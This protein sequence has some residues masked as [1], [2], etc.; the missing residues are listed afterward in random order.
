[1]K[2]AILHLRRSDPVLRDVIDRVG[3]YRQPMAPA[4][5]PAL[6][7]S[8]VYQQLHGKAAATIFGRLEAALRGRLTPAGVLRLPEDRM[9]WCGLSRQKTASLRDLARR[10]WSRELDFAALPRLA[11]AEVVAR[12][13]AVKGVG[14]WTA[15]MF[16]LFALGRPDV[17][18]TADLGV[19]SAMKNLYGLAELPKPAEMERI[20]EPWRPYRSVACWYLW[21]SLD[22]RA[23]LPQVCAGDQ[24]P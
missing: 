22:E 11:D 21:R 23:P 4:D 14:V 6:A 18:P 13:T 7:R 20:A 5:F 24:R 9:R 1:M 10:T 15:Q 16:L 17:L 8:I 12:L 19:R 3:P 2:Q